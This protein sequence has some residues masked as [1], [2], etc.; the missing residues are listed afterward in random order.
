MLTKSVNHILHKNQLPM[1]SQ[2]TSEETEPFN[3][4]GSGRISLHIINKYSRVNVQINKDI[5]TYTNTKFYNNDIILNLNEQRQK[6][7]VF[8]Y[9]RYYYTNKINSH[10]IPI[11]LIFEYYNDIND[12]YPG[13]YLSKYLYFTNSIHV[14]SNAICANDKHLWPQ[15]LMFNHNVVIKH[16]FRPMLSYLILSFILGLNKNIIL[17]DIILQLFMN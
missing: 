11:D 6:K 4:Y 16:K 8:C 17:P 5:D 15:S 3:L 2:P 13:K 9:L 14:D 12:I 10:S 1:Q 7:L